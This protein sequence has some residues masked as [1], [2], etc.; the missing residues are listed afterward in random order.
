MEPEHQAGARAIVIVATALWAVTVG[1]GF[2]VGGLEFA[3]GASLGGALA[4][5]NFQLMRRTAAR[6]LGLAPPGGRWGPVLGTLRW[7]GTA[8]ALV[9]AIWVLP[10]DPVGLLVGLSVVVLAI[11]IAAALGLVRG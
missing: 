1:A 7:A 4:L 5:V 2:L 3:A 10:V 9:A 11:G 8:A 6:T